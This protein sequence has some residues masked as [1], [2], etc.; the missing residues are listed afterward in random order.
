MQPSFICIGFQKCGTTTLFDLLRQHPGLVFPRGVKEPMYYRIPGVRR[1]WGKDGYEKRYFGDVPPGDGRLPG[2]INAGLS[3]SGCAEKLKRDFSPETKLIF[4]MRDPAD[5]CYSAY[6]YFLARGFLPLS[7]ARDD[8][9]NG[10]AAAFGRYVRSVLLS[11]A[12]RGAI[13]EKRMKYLCFSQGNY[14]ALMEELI[15]YFPHFRCILFEEFVRNQEGTCKSLYEFLGVPPDERVTY[16]L[17][18]N[19]GNLR[20]AGPVRARLSEWCK[21]AD[22][23][24][25]EVLDLSRHLPALS[26]GYA[27]FTRRVQARCMKP[28]PDRSKMDG[29]TRSLLQDYYRPEKDRTAALLGRSLDEIWFR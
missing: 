15:P 22:Y 25:D 3:F 9:E 26:R 14:A 27:A 24:Q 16:G 13:M 21:G 6:K 8:L 7:V 19:E 28:D 10:H 1:L 18:S 17:R 12:R 29:E 23:F 11:P 4:M 20:L 2:E 5:R